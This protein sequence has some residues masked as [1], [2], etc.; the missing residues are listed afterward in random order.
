MPAPFTAEEVA[1]AFQRAP[2]QIK[3]VLA[4][5]IMAARLDALEGVQAQ[6]V[7]NEEVTDEVQ[8]EE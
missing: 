7:P 2:E 1:F 4:N 8:D 5:I 3:L 6:Y